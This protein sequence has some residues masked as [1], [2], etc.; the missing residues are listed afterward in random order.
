MKSHF[1][2]AVCAS[3]ISL[4]SVSANAAL[5]VQDSQTGSYQISFNSPIGQTFTAEDSAIVSIGFFIADLNASFAPNDFDLTAKLYEGV[6]DSGVLLSS[7]TFSGLSTG[8]KGFVDFD[9]NA[10][11]LQVGGTYTAV[12]END[13]ERWSVGKNTICRKTGPGTPVQCFTETDYIGGSAIVNGTLDTNEDLMFTVS[14]S[15]VPLPASIYLFGSGLLG[16]TAIAKRK[17]V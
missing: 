8:F 15:S 6:G 2:G 12:I 5:I 13:T 4:I 14:P 1:S 11:G 16:L 17:T 7:A 9:L 10:S 3:V